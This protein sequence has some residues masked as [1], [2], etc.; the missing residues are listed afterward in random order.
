MQTIKRTFKNILFSLPGTRCSDSRPA[1]P[2]WLPR[3]AVH[4]KQDQTTENLQ[5]GR[6]N[7]PWSVIA[8]YF[9]QFQ[10]SSSSEFPTITLSACED[11]SDDD[12]DDDG[13]LVQKDS[14]IDVGQVI[15]HF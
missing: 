12:S 9:C 4:E 5:K 11:D 7:F 2:D 15:K 6:K 1:A 10:S 8:N 14:F 3:P 13:D